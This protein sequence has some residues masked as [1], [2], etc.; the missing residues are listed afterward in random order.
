MQRRA[1][2]ERMVMGAKAGALLGVLYCG[3]ATVS[4]V[5]RGTAATAAMGV[6]LP[7]LFAAYLI[8]GPASGAVAAILF[9]LGRTLAGALVVGFVSIIPLILGGRIVLRGLARWDR[10]DSVVIM[11]T[12]LFIGGLTGVLVH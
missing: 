2:V 3:I 5:V 8:G 11:A 12:A 9:P 1:I 4:F 7:S 6:G 10:A